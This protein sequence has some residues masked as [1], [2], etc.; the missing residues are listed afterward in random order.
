MLVS[1]LAENTSMWNDLEECHS[2]HWVCLYSGLLT[3]NP[4]DSSKFS[5]VCDHTVSDVLHSTSKLRPGDKAVYP[6]ILYYQT[7]KQCIEVTSTLLDNLQCVH[8]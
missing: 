8:E 3:N 2:K 4:G 5:L 7:I 6:S 1:H